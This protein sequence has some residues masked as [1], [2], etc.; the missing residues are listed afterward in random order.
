MKQLQK[1][2]V[3]MIT[4]LS[5][6][7]SDVSFKNMIHDDTSKN[8]NKEEGEL[9][10]KIRYEKLKFSFGTGNDYKPKKITI[11]N[12]LNEEHPQFSINFDGAQNKFISK[13][14]SDEKEKKEFI[15]EAKSDLEKVKKMVY[16]R[17]IVGVGSEDHWE[18]W[19]YVPELNGT[20][21]G[22]LVLKDT[23]LLELK[24]PNTNRREK[25]VACEILT[26]AEGENKPKVK[27]YPM[28]IIV[29]GEKYQQLCSKLNG[30]TIFYKLGKDGKVLLVWDTVRSQFEFFVYR[31]PR[32]SPLDV[33]NIML[34]DDLT[35]TIQYISKVLKQATLEL[36]ADDLE[37]IDALKVLFKDKWAIVQ[38][39]FIALRGMLVKRVIRGGALVGG[40]GGFILRDKKDGKK[41]FKFIS[42]EFQPIL[43]GSEL[44][45]KQ[46]N[47][48]ELIYALINQDE[49][50]ADFKT[51][52][53]EG[54]VEK[55]KAL[56]EFV[57][58]T[59]LS[60]GDNRRRKKLRKYFI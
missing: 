33:Y 32:Y 16:D 23:N 15:D 19:K 34:G 28:N 59:T 44:V 18:A 24:Y 56:L 5:G 42:N 41:E 45:E 40:N 30:Q 39:P 20:E 14:V 9:E 8:E 22:L 43:F 27:I 26:D 54:D 17:W 21:E 57:N 11:V 36:K 31:Q 50:I 12:K 13:P 38:E 47:G 7:L 6:V 58:P 25:I 55:M 1:L 35:I 51:L 49:N 37:M 10:V 3:L 48:K 46:P 29:E 2:T 52:P 4:L 60:T 53:I